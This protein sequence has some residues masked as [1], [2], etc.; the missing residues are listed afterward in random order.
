LQDSAERAKEAEAPFRL[1]FKESGEF[2]M[3]GSILGHPLQEVCTWTVKE[4]ADTQVT[5]ELHEPGREPDPMTFEFV[6]P[7][8]IRTDMPIGPTFFK[9]VE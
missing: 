6:E 4:E 1:T 8:V 9:R 5:V 7:T 2:V 3:E